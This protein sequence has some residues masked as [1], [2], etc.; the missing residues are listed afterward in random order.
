MCVHVCVCVFVCAHVCVF[1]C[2]CVRVCVCVC[3]CVCGVCVCA[4]SAE[5]EVK[6]RKRKRGDKVRASEDTQEEADPTHRDT[7]QKDPL[8]TRTQHRRELLESRI[9]SSPFS[10]DY[11]FWKDRVLTA[12]RAKVA[13][14]EHETAAQ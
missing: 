8:H 1:V 5:R 12:A 14:Q 13:S 6:G 2:A 11:L 4:F 9:V 10:Q 7:E 3:V